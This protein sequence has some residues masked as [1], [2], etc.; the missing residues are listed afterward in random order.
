MVEHR[1]QKLMRRVNNGLGGFHY[2]TEHNGCM[3]DRVLETIVDEKIMKLVMRVL[4]DRAW[5]AKVD[6]KG[7]QSVTRDSLLNW[8]K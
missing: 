3:N 4:F 7:I 1:K 8:T 6:K 2:Q 5:E